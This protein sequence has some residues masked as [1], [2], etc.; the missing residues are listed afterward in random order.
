[1]K[2]KFFI[3][4]F[5]L[6]A[7]LMLPEFAYAATYYVDGT[8]GNNSNNGLS[9]GT[10]FK[11]ITK[12]VGNGLMAGDTVLIRG[13]VYR[14]KLGMYYVQGT[15][16][17]PIIIK[18]Y[19]S[20]EVIIDGSTEV[21][22]WTLDSGNIYKTLPGFTVA[23]VI[24]DDT[25]LMPAVA[26]TNSASGYVDTTTRASVTMHAGEFYQDN[27][28][29]ELYVWTPSGASPLGNTTLGVLAPR[30]ALNDVIYMWDCSYLNF[31]NLTVRFGNSYGIN[32]AGD[33]AD[34]HNN[35]KNLKIKFNG[36]TGIS[37]GP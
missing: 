30:E 18:N 33:G 35:Y 8:N 7:F 34:G 13:G 25:V 28:T 9:V 16:G 19:D 29:G 12:A 20:N 14:E 5:L 3:T 2:N 26:Q 11:T 36:H 17:N 23:E 15:A 22:G 32:S 31:E 24:I 4:L 6:S 21:T 10:A 37:T 1:M 27:S